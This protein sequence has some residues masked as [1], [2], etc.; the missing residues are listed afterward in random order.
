[1]ITIMT[2]LCIL[3]ICGLFAGSAR[4]YT[5]TATNW[6]HRQQYVKEYDTVSSTADHIRR[7]TSLS[8]N[9]AV[10]PKTAR[11]EEVHDVIRKV[12]GAFL[13]TSGA[14]IARSA[15][16]VADGDSPVITRAD[17]GFINLNETMP[18]VTDVCWMDV[19]IGDAEPQ[20]V[21]ISLFGMPFCLSAFLPF[22]LSAFL[23]FCLLFLGIK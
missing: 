19:A 13:L 6:R 1:M 2:P 16:A 15:V 22:C 12:S 10:H 5:N 9:H 4:A 18:E 7:S 11:D 23:P 17:V 20:R 3:V 21:E 8:I 14:V